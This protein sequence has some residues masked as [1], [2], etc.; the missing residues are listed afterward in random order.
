MTNG[1]DLKHLEAFFLEAASE[2]YAGGTPKTTITDLPRSKVYRFERGQ[3][4]YVDT[5]FTNGSWSGGQTVIYV[6]LV[7]TWLMQYNGWCKDDDKDVLAFLKKALQAQYFT[8]EF[9]GGRGPHELWQYDDKRT[10]SLVY[11]NHPDIYNRDFAYFQGRER[12]FRY[13]AHTTD[14]FWHRYQGLLLPSQQ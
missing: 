8:G 4:L 2:T 11:R 5:Y 13:P 9:F 7:P 12:I 10:G 6:D 14:L 1:I 3:F